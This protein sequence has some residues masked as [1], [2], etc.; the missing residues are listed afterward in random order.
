VSKRKKRQKIFKIFL[1]T[2]YCGCGK[3]GIIFSTTCAKLGDNLPF[4]P[5]FLLS[6]CGKLLC[7]IMLCTHRYGGK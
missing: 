1:K 2:K 6:S 4:Q 3:M 7:D 5:S